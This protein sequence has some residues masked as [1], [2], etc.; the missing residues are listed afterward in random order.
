MCA[1]ALAPSM[2][3]ADTIRWELGSFAVAELSGV[4]AS[5]VDGDYIWSNYATNR[6][7]YG[8]A[9]RGTDTGDLYWINYGSGTNSGSVSTVESG[10]TGIY[11]SNEPH[12]AFASGA[13]PP[14]LVECEFAGVGVYAGEKFRFDTGGRLVR[15]RETLRAQGIDCEFDV[16]KVY[17]GP[18]YSSLTLCNKGS[19]GWYTC[20]NNIS[21]LVLVCTTTGRTAALTNVSHYY[22]FGACPVVVVSKPDIGS[23]AVRQEI[24]S[25]TQREMST[26]GSGT[27]ASNA[28]STNIQ[29]YENLGAVQQLGTLFADIQQAVYT[30]ESN[31]TVPFP[32]L[33]VMGFVIPAAEIDVWDYLPSVQTP[34][35]L[36]VTFVFS[37]AFISHIVHFLQ[38]IFG[39]Y[40][41]GDSVLSEHQG[42]VA[43]PTVVQWQGD[44]SVDE[45]LGF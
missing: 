16:S 7:W 23:E 13:N 2:A 34:V 12:S 38:A 20:Q 5:A 8:L 1:C 42:Y 28:V 36:M 27:I 18:D 10:S 45:D 31:S 35:R 30:T 17:A 4:S 40:E 21:R 29:K 24:A 44:Y 6:R 15:Y 9:Y 39:I 33:S 11:R 43:G 37:V 41:Y 32:G 22:E 26:T 19:D 25:Q 3:L 14:M